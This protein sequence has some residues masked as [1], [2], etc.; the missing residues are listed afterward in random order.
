VSQ[1][2]HG[3]GSKAPE[4][5]TIEELGRFAE[6]VSRGANDTITQ[7]NGT[8]L[9]QSRL[10]EHQ[11]REL[12]RANDT[13]KALQNEVAELKRS[14]IDRERLLVE[15][16][17]AQLTIEHREK[18][19][20]QGMGV[21]REVAAPI[22]MQLALSQGATGGSLGSAMTEGAESKR[23]LELV[24]TDIWCRLS[25]DTIKR[26]QAEA[27]NDLVYELLSQVTGGATA[28]SQPAPNGVNGEKTK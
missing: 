9:T 21:V 1:G 24:L 26:L 22:L 8:V 7:L 2:G 28:E 5:A 4:A 17:L 20:A 16:K 23:P 27:G 13:I 14:D 15:A 25:E 11:A 19:F 10:I 12:E 6:R 3:R 18:R